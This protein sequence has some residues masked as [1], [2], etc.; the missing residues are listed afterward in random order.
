M[1]MTMKM[2]IN[3][4]WLQMGSITSLFYDDR[5]NKV[6]DEDDNDNDH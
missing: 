6:D 2:T 5:H 3:V 4:S 1:I